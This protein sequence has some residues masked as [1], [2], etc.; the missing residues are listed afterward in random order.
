MKKIAREHGRL[1][2]D[3]DGKQVLPVAYMSYLPTLANFDKFRDIG[4][5]FF[6]VCL[7]MGDMPINGWSGI[8]Q[9]DDSVWKSRNEYDFS[10]VDKNLSLA[11]DNTDAYVLLRI[12]VNAPSWW[13]K[14]NPDECTVMEDGKMPYQSVFSQK[15]IADA[16][17]F[18]EKLK[19]HIDK[20]Q[21]ADRVIG[22]QIAAMNTEEW[23]APSWKGV[24]SDFSLVA[25]NFF[26]NWC[27]DKYKTL[28]NLNDAWNTNYLSFDEITVPKGEERTKRDIEPIVDL[29]KYARI[30]D[31]YY[32]LNERYSTASYELTKF[33]KQLFNGDILVG[34]F[35]G[36]IATG[37]MW[38]A[39]TGIDLL[40]NSPYIDF[41][42]CPFPYVDQ[43]KS[44][45]DWFYQS[46]VNSCER[47]D[48]IWFLEGDI[49]T[50]KTKLLYDVD[51]KYVSKDSEYMVMPTWLGPKDE[52]QSFWHLTKAFSKVLCS[53]NAFWWFDM[54][55]GWYD[56]PSLQNLLFRMRNE[57]EKEMSLPYNSDCE[58]AVIIDSQSSYAISYSQFS[59]VVFTQ[60]CEV[61]FVGA[62]YDLYIKSMVN[63]KDLSR[64]K[65]VIYVAPYEISASDID[66]INT[67]SSNGIT[68]L[69]T[70]RKYVVNAKNFINTYDC[71][72][73]NDLKSYCKKA[74][75]HLYADEKAVVYK[76]ERHICITAPKD[77]DYELSFKRDCLLTSFISGKKIKTENKK[78][79]ITLKEQQSELFIID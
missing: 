36:Y 77:G 13:L 6:S 17:T 30:N 43:R 1:F 5:K 15:W 53:S 2:I 67:L 3:V 76:S 49:R 55:G 42:A 63:S 25:N 74:G 27:K 57:Y 56:T 31:W 7:Y 48:K 58:I 29:S 39:H 22:W 11:I 35:Y 51:P 12:N 50:H 69:I 10:V 70:G 24:E 66:L 68:V 40:L 38:C 32:C 47:V 60:M 44:P 21:Y 72:N 59:K 71:V 78:V 64:Y 16:K 28:S 14:E 62:P 65:L 20:S 79:T 4:Y 26:I 46:G 9:L 23:L 75:V 61:G 54:W 41:F 73:A 52:E 34:T 37:A 18:L 33:I 45:T 8:R 19:E